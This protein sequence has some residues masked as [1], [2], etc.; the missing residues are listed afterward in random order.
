VPSGPVKRGRSDGILNPTNPLHSKKELGMNVKRINDGA[1]F[2]GA[3]L[4][5]LS[6][7]LAA[8]ADYQSTVLSQGPVG[9]WRLNETI[10]PQVAVP[11]ANLGSLGTSVAGT[12]NS[13]PTRGLEGP[14]AGSTAVGFEGAPQSVTTPW[15]AGM[16][17]SSF[18]VELW[19]NP[20][21][22]PNFAYVASSAVIASPRS[23][24]YLAQD[25]GGTFGAG[26]AFVVR[27]FNQNGTTPTVQLA[28]PLP[29]GTNVW[30]HLVLTYDGTTASLYSNG[31]LV[32]NRA[33]AYVPNVS[34]PFSIGARSDAAFNWP[35]KAAE[36]AMYGSALSATQVANHY[37]AATGAP[38]TYA[39]TVQADSPLVYYRFREAIDPPAE[40]LG[41]LGAG[42]KG[43]YMY[44][45]RAGVAG[46]S[47]PKYA[48]MEAAN[49]AVAFGGTG[50]AIR[51]PALNLK[52]NTVTITA[53]VNATNVQPAGAGLVFN[54]SGTTV[55]G[56]TI[57]PVFGGTGLG[58]NWNGDAATTSW[59]PTRDSS[60][61]ALP[62][63]EWAFVALTVSPSDAAL[64]ICDSTN[65]LNFMGATNNAPNAVQA[66]EGVTYFGTD[67]VDTAHN[68]TGALD[69]VAIFNRTL[70]VGEIYSQYAAAVGGVPVRIFNDPQAPVD[71]LYT[72][73]TISLS[74]D[75][76]G[77]PNLTYQWRKDSGAIAGATSSSFVKANVATTDSGSYDCV[78]K[79]DFGQVT[80]AG[81]SIT[82]NP[83]F[84]P[85][86]TTPP[87]AHPLYPGGTLALSVVGTGGGLRYQWSKGGVAI[88]GAT[89]SSYS[90][91][92]V[93]T[94]DAGAYSV[95]VNNNVGSTTGGPVSLAVLTPAN[96]YEAAIVA[97]KPEAW[98]RL[99]E[100]GGTEIWDSMGRHDG[101]YA[102]G[103][104]VTMG[105]AGVVV[106]STDKAASFDGA[107]SSY[108]IVPFSPRLNSQ[109]FAIE[110][111]AKTDTTADL[112]PVSS[113]SSTPDGYWLRTYPAGAWSGGVA[114]GTSGFYVPSATAAD[115]I[116]AGQWKH[117][118][119]VYDGSLK[120]YVNGQWDGG[121]YVD[122]KRNSS[123]P[124]IIGALGATAPTAPSGFFKGQIDEILVY[125][126]G[127]TLAQAQSHYSKALYP[128]PIPP[129][130]VVVPSSQEVL[131]NAAATV[132]L[133]GS[134]DGPIPITYQWY[135][136]GA[137][138]AGAT[139]TAL[140]LSCTFS[141][142]G[143]YVLRA[144]NGT[145]ST[146][147]P[148]AGLAILPPNPPFVNVTNGLVLH[149]KFDGDYAD[150]SGRGNNGTA[151]GTPTL[152]PGR[153]GNAVFISTSND[154]PSVNYVTLG[155]PTDLNFGTS[156]DFSVSYWV[157]QEA[158]QTNGDLPFLC[159]APNSYGGPGF[160]FAPSYKQGGW[161]FS[162]NG[163]VQVY[164]PVNSINDGN[165]HHVLHTFKRTGNAITYVDGARADTRP[166][167]PA[168]NL[169]TG[170]TVNIGQDPTG[171]YAEDGSATLDDLAVWRRA[172]T[173]YEAY[174]IY[175][176]AT[177][178]NSSFDI[179]GTVSL[180]VGSSG[181][182]VVFS[183]VPGATLGT[184]FEADDLLGPW[185]PVGAYAPT[186][187]V[188]PAAAK[189]FYRLGFSE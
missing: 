9:Y 19:A 8:R 43:L 81:A 182:K 68:F 45:A 29:N 86:I 152:V 53:W 180:Q 110:C 174:A 52:T 2:V 84:T 123:A 185:T 78:V 55:V 89:Q 58:Y 118:V 158:G 6:G 119:M 23:G 87:T 50:G 131:S 99:N 129:F 100:T 113:H 136:D 73:D 44:D 114:N 170:N 93:T 4:L 12:Y 175:N 142:A 179:P 102:S 138:V 139:T 122:F 74:V 46:P 151:V 34:A 66:F 63:S 61:A 31:A 157:K 109:N 37:A 161:S 95:S 135:K 188:T 187:S 41:S 65:Y 18:T 32:T 189:K 176:S 159:S 21:I 88:A 147:T 153:L 36:V 111:W 116:V 150:A 28:A 83:A 163:S 92:G 177:N 48:G 103:S 25:N 181:G 3:V 35:G 27:F 97:D 67:P 80:S 105:V 49:K 30:Y 17:T 62:D 133:T 144:T 155:K 98:Y 91:Y 101:A 178:R 149:L 56:L 164:G 171:A 22:V 54:R 141:N 39:A 168:G 125:T 165:W 59:S 117:V 169:D 51:I 186:Y 47:A 166:C 167:N 16:N 75:A 96:D 24:W 13:F 145:G 5:A 1:R 64:F 76:G 120:V 70:A 134:A 124:F 94:N 71:P 106:G 128:T 20:S 108:G 7:T 130:W 11:T 42:A 140:A 173:E 184:L 107:T 82:V 10:Q 154:V 15:Q 85:T 137:A 60:L 146:N 90:I 40:N 162:L 127:L 148:A 156:T 104:T 160:T 77:T 72:G 57:D 132:T 126:N 38:A 112:T 121:T 26:S 143:S 172:L 33:A 115:G 183:W 79:N 14:F 69:D